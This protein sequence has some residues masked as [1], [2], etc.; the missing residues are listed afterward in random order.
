MTNNID[1]F[2]EKYGDVFFSAVQIK[3]EKLNTVPIGP[4]LDYGMHGGI[5]E[6]TWTVITGPEKTG[7]TTIALQ[8]ARNA[9]KLYNKHIYLTDAEGRFGQLNTASVKDLDL[10]KLT[11]IKSTKGNILSA[12]KHL[13]IGLDI[14]KSVPECVY[15]I[16]STSALCA[17]EELSSEIKSQTRILGPKLLASFCRQA[18]QVVP[19]NKTIIILITHLISNTSGYGSPYS[20]DSG[21]KIKYQYQNKLRCK[22]S[23]P[24][25]DKENKQIGQISSWLIEGTALGSKG[26]TIE[27]YIRYGHGIDEEMEIIE[28]GLSFGI[29]KKAGAWFS[30]DIFP[31]K[32]QGQEK[33]HEYLIN[34]HDKFEELNKQVKNF[35]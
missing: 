24:W 21:R 13:D 29:I 12:Q 5:L 22:K 11:V 6:G 4:M 27:S 33:L 35:L 30:S 14:I 1:S 7:K 34:N 18:G 26:Q 3:E 28:F 20:E 15:I 19:V 23:E 10:D 31:D 9:Q 16:D 25:L 8:I 32:I 2:Q 17:E